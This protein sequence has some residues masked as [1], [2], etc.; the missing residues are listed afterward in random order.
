MEENLWDKIKQEIDAKKQKNH[1]L[2]LVIEQQKTNCLNL[3]KALNASIL[4]DCS[5]NVS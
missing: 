4:A 1:Q 3:A 5:M 2:N